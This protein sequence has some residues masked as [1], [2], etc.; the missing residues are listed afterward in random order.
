M[1]FWIDTSTEFAKQEK[2][3]MRNRPSLITPL[4]AKWRNQQQQLLFKTLGVTTL[5]AIVIVV[6]FQFT[7]ENMFVVLV[8]IL[9]LK[10][11]RPIENGHVERVLILKKDFTVVTII[12]VLEIVVS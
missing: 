6:I 1:S 11:K 10:L 7:Q 4:S 9:F 2:I 12:S 5:L 8:M 3:E